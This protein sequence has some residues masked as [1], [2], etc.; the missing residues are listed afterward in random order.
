MRTSKVLQNLNRGFLL[1]AVIVFCVALFLMLQGMADDK[2]EPELKAMAENFMAESD[3]IVVLPEEYR[4]FRGDS[5]ELRTLNI[6]YMQIIDDSSSVDNQFYSDNSQLRQYTLS[7]LQNCAGNQI[8]NQVYITS[9]KTKIVKFRSF[10]VYKGKATLAFDVLCTGETLTA[11]GTNPLTQAG[12]DT[13]TFEKEN[14]KWVIT[15]YLTRR[16]D[17]LYYGNNPEGNA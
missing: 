12:S 7:W 10:S 3:T 2:L 17:F 16:F 8:D 11:E 4:V 5:E 15:N 13:L 1:S 9:F 6:D 14:G